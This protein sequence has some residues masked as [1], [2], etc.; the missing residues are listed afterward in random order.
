VPE[1]LCEVDEGNLGAIKTSSFR[2][3]MSDV[4]ATCDAASSVSRIPGTTGTSRLVGVGNVGRVSGPVEVACCVG[5]GY[6]D[7]R[8]TACGA[9]MVECVG[10]HCCGCS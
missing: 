6:G 3:R 4:F 10:C 7:R 9:T 2:M 1:Y 5:V 8:V